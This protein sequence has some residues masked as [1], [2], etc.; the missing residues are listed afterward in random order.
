MLSV[1]PDWWVKATNEAVYIIRV[2]EAEYLEMAR[3]VIKGG[4]DKKSSSVTVFSG[5]LN[6]PSLPPNQKTEQR[7]MAEAESIVGAGTLTS[8][9][10]LSLTTYFVLEDPHILSKLSAELSTAMPDASSSPNMQVFESLSY[11]NAVID[12][13]LRMSYGSM[14]RLSRS[15]PNSSLQYGDWVIPPGTPLGYSAYLVHNNPKLF[16]NPKEFNPERWTRLGSSE[17]MRLRSHLNM[18]GRGTR[19]CAGM[20]LA[21]AEIYF[22]LGYLFRRLGQRMQ[23]YDTEYARDVEYVRDFF[24]PAP[25][26]QSKG[27]RVVARK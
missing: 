6:E 3:G 5:I 16:P 17:R 21:Y 24:I 11:L 18:F 14:H 4:A 9:H 19:Q 7:M 20:R 8:A 10:M 1:L 15:H 13:G 12:E 26:L 23:L 22:T 2:Q 27:C 25:S